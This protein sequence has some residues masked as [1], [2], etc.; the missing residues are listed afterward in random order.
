M[1]KI[2]LDVDLVICDPGFLFLINKFLNT[3]YTLEDFTDYYIDDILGDD[4]NKEKFYK[5]YL[6][7][8]P[9]DYMELYENA[10]EVI[11]KL[12]KKYDIYICSACV[13]P[14]FIQDS[15]KLFMYKYNWLIKTLPFLD[16]YKF[17]FTSTKN[18]FK[19]DIQIDDRLDNLKNDIPERFLF[20]SYHN[21]NITKEELDN[22]GVIRVNNWKEIEQLLLEEK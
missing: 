18:S 6:Q 1:K 8:N 22:A 11:E 12:N 3:N 2:L 14:F 17:I 20:D 7:N 9:Y 16:P 13:N 5:F 19:A 10:Y 15:G 4:S 21:K